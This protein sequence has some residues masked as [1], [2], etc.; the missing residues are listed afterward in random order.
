[1]GVVRMFSQCSSRLTL[2]AAPIELDWGYGLFA[3]IQKF[4]LGGDGSAAEDGE[5]A[6]EAEPAVATQDTELG[7]SAR[8]PDV[9]TGRGGDGEAAAD[10]E[11]G[12]AAQDTEPGVAARLPDAQA[13]WRRGRCGAGKR[14]GGGRSRAGRGSPSHRGGRG[15]SAA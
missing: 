1:M 5:A 11:P 4:G 6:E 10:A 13:G 14:L 8:L 9:Q 3:S 12:V 7:V 15:R 2:G